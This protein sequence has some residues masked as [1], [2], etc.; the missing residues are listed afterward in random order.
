M[1]IFTFALLAAGFAASAATAQNA[2]ASSLAGVWILDD[3]TATVQIAPC[4]E[5]LC[6]KLIAEKLQPG[7]PSQLGQTIIRDVRLNGKKGWSG[8]YIADGSS[9]GL[10]IKQSGANLMTAKICAAFFACDTL[11]LK[12]LQ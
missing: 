9:Y 5:S 11:R 2:P 1:R 4:G 8:K 7:E 3:G 10:K 12:R 6:G